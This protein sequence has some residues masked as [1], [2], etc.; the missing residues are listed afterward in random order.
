M[1]RSRQVK[2]IYL[3][4]YVSFFWKHSKSYFFS[5]MKCVVYSCNLASFHIIEH[6]NFL[7]LSILKD[8]LINPFPPFLCFYFSHILVT[9]IYSSLLWYQ[10]FQIPHMIQTM[11]DLSF[12]AWLISLNIMTSNSIYI[13]SNDRISFLT[14]EHSVVFVY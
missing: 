7:F 13:V 9:I 3:L 2:Y 11:W 5:F 6:R 10:F 12:C 1:L 4:K 14:E 8:P